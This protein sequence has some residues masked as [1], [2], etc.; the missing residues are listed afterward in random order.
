MGAC[1]GDEGSGSKK[2]T[3]STSGG[4]QQ[5]FPPVNQPGV[6]A[7]EIRVTGVAA[8]T[9]PTGN[10]YGSAFDGVQAYFDMVNSEGGIYGR[11]LAIGKRRDDMLGNNRREV[12]AAIEQDKPFAVL[13]AATVLF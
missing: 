4:A 10:S 8:A 13:P 12:L 1:S 6:T 3:T 5:S 2:S 11:K 9:N 7:S